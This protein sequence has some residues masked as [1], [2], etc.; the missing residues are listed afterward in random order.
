MCI[1]KTYLKDSVMLCKSSYSLLKSKVTNIF[2]VRCGYSEKL[3]TKLWILFK[4]LTTN[5]LCKK[6]END[7]T[8]LKVINIYKF[9][10]KSK[11]LSSKTFSL[12]LI[13]YNYFQRLLL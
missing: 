6:G 12:L 5:S 8:H 11:M 1:S 3:S 13:N 2:T 10:I 4:K 7:K 9:K